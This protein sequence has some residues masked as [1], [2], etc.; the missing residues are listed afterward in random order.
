MPKC[1]RPGCRWRLRTFDA[2]QP[3]RDRHG[4]DRSYPVTALDWHRVPIGRRA[5]TAAAG[6]TSAATA[7]RA[8]ASERACVRPAGDGDTLSLRSSGINA[9]IDTP[10]PARPAGRYQRRRLPALGRLS[11]AYPSWGR[12]SCS[13]GPFSLLGR[14]AARPGRHQHHHAQYLFS[15][16]QCRPERQPPAP[17]C[18]CHHAARRAGSVAGCRSR[19]SRLGLLLPT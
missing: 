16:R 17:R 10:L 8:A 4:V 13:D 5:A 3:A 11:T 7:R 6:R 19:L 2:T 1:A 15:G 18:C 14:R 12:W 9:A